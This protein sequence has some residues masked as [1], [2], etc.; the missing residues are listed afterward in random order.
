[1]L[2]WNF[3]MLQYHV[4]G[5]EDFIWP[6]N[7]L[8]VNSK[9]LI[10]LFG[11]NG[12]DSDWLKSQIPFWVIWKQLLS[13]PFI[14][15]HAIFNLWSPLLPAGIARRFTCHL[16]PPP[17]PSPG[18]IC[19]IHAY[20][21]SL[22]RYKVVRYKKF[23]FLVMSAVCLLSAVCLFSY[24]LCYTCRYDLS[25]ALKSCWVWIIMILWDVSCLFTFSWFINSYLYGC[26]GESW[27]KVVV[28]DVGYRWRVH[29][30]LAQ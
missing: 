12:D 18:N 4:W 30:D 17:S 7:I 19:W 16:W 8:M 21:T 24:Q 6:A 22:M 15:D 28:T 29:L 25:D 9:P 13:V 23:W 2:S 27:L 14:R 11:G 1:M 5:L 20:M 26:A 10:E 3:E